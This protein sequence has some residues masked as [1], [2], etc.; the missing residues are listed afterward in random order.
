MGANRSQEADKEQS[1]SVYPQV[2]SAA[3]D[4]GR[5]GAE[6]ISAVNDAA[7]VSGRDGRRPRSRRIPADGQHE[8]RQMGIRKGGEVVYKRWLDAKDS[9]NSFPSD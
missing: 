7:F 2:I 5:Q 8:D 1:T 9:A 6:S 4:D 3:A